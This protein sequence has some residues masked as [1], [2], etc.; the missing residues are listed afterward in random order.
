MAEF[1]AALISLTGNIAS[2]VQGKTVAIYG[3]TLRGSY[4]S[5]TDKLALHMVSSYATDMN[6]V[7]G[8]QGIDDKYNEIPT[9][10][11]LIEMLDLKGAV[12]TA[13]AMHCQREAVVKIV[14][15][16]AD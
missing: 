11:R 15:K 7:I 5:S 6:L 4:D 8:L 3:K 12:V 1:N 14:G 13:D 2:V 10:H 9:S 16:R